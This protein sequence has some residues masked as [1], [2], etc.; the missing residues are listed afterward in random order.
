MPTKLNF[1]NKPRKP[2]KCSG[3]K[4]KKRVKSKTTKKYI[5]GQIKKWHKKCWDLQSEI[6]RRL[7]HGICYTCRTG[8][9]WRTRQ[10]G[11][12]I[13][14]KLDFDRRNL[15]CQCI[16]CNH[17]KSGNLGEYALHLM[18]DIGIDGVNQLK[19][20][21]MKSLTTGLKRMEVE[22]YQKLYTEL[23]FEIKQLELEGII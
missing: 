8:G 13:H 17:Y 14:D 6:I 4:K 3:F 12:F 1:F 9:D 15:H 16:A 7:A 21:A 10:T 23:E 19:N 11:H 2:L 20:D 22:D 5:G 18:E